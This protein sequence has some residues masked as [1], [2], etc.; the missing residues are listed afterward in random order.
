[1]RIAK[2]ICSV[3]LLAGGTASIAAQRIAAPVR[4]QSQGPRLIGSL[5]PAERK[6]FP[7]SSPPIGALQKS[8]TQMAR[9]R[10]MASFIASPAP[11][12]FEIAA[13]IS[14]ILA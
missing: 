14:E 11:M 13:Q 7:C 1:M 9:G 5:T 2:I 4:T 3:L 8:G 12:H 10:D 6:Q